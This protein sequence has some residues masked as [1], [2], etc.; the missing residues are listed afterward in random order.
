MNVRY[1]LA[2]IR[3]YIGIGIVLASAEALWL[4]QSLYGGSS[5]ATI[6]LQE[7]YAWLSVALL[8]SAV[9]IGPLLKVFPGLPWRTQLHESRRLVGIGAAWFGFWHAA[10]SYVGLFHAA[11]LSS[12]AGLYQRSFALGMLALIILLLMAFTS[13]DKAFH[14]MGKWWF[15]L[16]R[17]VY[18]AVLAAV[19][20]A[21]MI[22]TH[23]DSLVVIIVFAIVAAVLFSLHIRLCIKAQ[24][25]SKLL[26]I[27]LTCMILFAIAILNYGLTQ[28]L[29]YDPVLPGHGAG[30]HAYHQ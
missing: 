8:L 27:T 30:V 11:R 6:R 14:S 3:L 15:R 29:G 17:L 19:M 21:F 16:H 23:A 5:L 24:S 18:V 20:H 22:G 10:I 13:F 7:I 26:A 2:G 9:A 4:T 12:L 25:P 1:W 28:Y